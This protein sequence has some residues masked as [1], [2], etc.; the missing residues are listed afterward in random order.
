[1]GKSLVIFPNKCDYMI[2]EINIFTKHILVNMTII[3][4]IK[5]CV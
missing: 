5:I 2:D 1:M 4:K 3:K